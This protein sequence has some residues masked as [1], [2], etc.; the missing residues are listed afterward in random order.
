MSATPLWAEAPMESLR[1]TAR[2]ADFIKKIQP[3]AAELIAKANLNGAVGFSVADMSTG[4]LLESHNGAVGLPPASVAKSLTACYALQALGPGFQ[5]ETQ[6]M[7]TGGVIDGTVQGDLILI[8]GGDPTLDSDGLALLAA[9]MAAAGITGV[10]GGFKIWRGPYPYL[11]GIDP[12]QPDHVGYNPAVSG[13]NLNFNRVHFEWRKAGADYAISM[14]ARTGTHRPKVTMARM[15]VVSR[16]APVYTYADVGGRDDW[17]VA[18]GA[19]GQGGSR[20]LPVRKPGLYAGEVFQTFALA[21]GVRLGPP[22]LIDARPEGE[23]V[24]TLQSAPLRIIL[25][26]MLKWSTNLTAEMV[27]LTATLART[28]TPPKSLAESAEQMNAWGR[29]TLGLT[30]MAFVDHSGLG[31]ASRISPQDMMSG[32]RQLRLRLGIKPL[33]KSFAMRDDQRRVIEDH[34][35]DVHAKTG[36]LNFVS[37]LAGFVDLPDGTELVFAIFAADLERRAKLTKAQRERPDGGAAWNVR[38]KTLQQ[39]LI[40][41]WGVVHA[42]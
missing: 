19:L 37:G 7:A 24:A 6:V 12:G 34:P 3:D 5:F 39:A 20:W 26:D 10:Q 8:G 17:T 35:L 15:G 28:Q 18:R 41:R 13:L 21:H 29:E 16:S 30:S 9:D 38:A 2:S 31:E 1:P 14:D 33:L 25:R 42:S 27:G 11:R 36:T 22:E 32:L 23:I 4:D 40:E